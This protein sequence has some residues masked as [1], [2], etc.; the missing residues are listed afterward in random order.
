MKQI[1]EKFKALSEREQRLVLIATLV[2]AAL[3]FY[4]LVWSPLNQSIARNSA[5]V[6]DQQEL[7]SWVQKNANRVQQLKGSTSQGAKFNGSLPQAVNQSASRLNISIARMQPQGD[8]LQVWVDE[9]PFNQVIAWLHSL[10]Q[11]GIS[12][13][14]ADFA[15]TARP[16]QIRIRRLQLSKG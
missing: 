15:E 1:M 8:E 6:A 14:D 5:T 2:L 4:L 12:I 13:L 10:E 11:M 16:G 9:A 3:L 7:L